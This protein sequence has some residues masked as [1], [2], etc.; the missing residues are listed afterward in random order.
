[1]DFSICSDC[2]GLSAVRLVILW[3]MVAITFAGGA[4][5]V[6]LFRRLGGFARPLILVSLLS[7]CAALAV[8]V[9]VNPT[10]LT[11]GLPLAFL[12]GQLAAKPMRGSVT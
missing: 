10:L 5:S 11:F 9:A 8:A 3:V 2:A 4:T 1:M 6:L 7:T 12:A